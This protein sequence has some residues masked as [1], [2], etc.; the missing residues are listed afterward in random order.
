MKRTSTSAFLFLFV[1]PFATLFSG[2]NALIPPP[3]LLNAASGSITP[4]ASPAASVSQS[5]SAAST[6]LPV[7]LSH[8]LPEIHARIALPKDWT[9][10]PGK[11]L[12]GG[13]LIA[14]RE[15]ISGENDAWSTG[16][17]MTIDR[18]G[19]KDSGQKA[20]VYALGIAREAMSKVGDEASPMKESQSGPFHEIRFDFPV[21]GDPPLQITEVLRANDATDTL[22]VILWQ[23]PQAETKS[24]MGLREAILTGFVLDPTK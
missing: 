7:L 12:E 14:T 17:S 13:V 15:K 2:T 19:A 16:L 23:M 20:S 18:N 3:S 9:L 4:S 8:D 1:I 6:N 10:L 22:A 24:L 21:S 11:L 5:P